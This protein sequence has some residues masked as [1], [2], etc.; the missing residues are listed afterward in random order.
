MLS[1]GKAC[2]GNVHGVTREGLGDRIICEYRPEPTRGKE[3]T[4]A[5]TWD[6]RVTGRRMEH[7]GSN[8]GKHH[9]V[10][11]REMAGEERG[12]GRADP[13]REVNGGADDLQ[14]VSHCTHF[15]LRDIRSHYKI[16]R[17]EKHD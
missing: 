8:A 13:W 2:R 11:K 9:H 14:A 10:R 16:S 7:P 17:K 3:G 12:G 1:T 5:A 6:T 4:S 15:D